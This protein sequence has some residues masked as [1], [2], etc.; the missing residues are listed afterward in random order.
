MLVYVVYVA[1]DNADV[2][3]TFIQK[4]GSGT[5]SLIFNL[6]SAF[7]VKDSLS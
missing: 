1:T 3:V 2:L 6:K 7:S 4:S 5:I